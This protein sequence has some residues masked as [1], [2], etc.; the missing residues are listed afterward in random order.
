[1]NNKFLSK[2][3]S[4]FGIGLLVTFLVAYIVSTSISALSFIFS[5][6]TYLIIVLLE[7][8]V[9]IWLSARIHKM[10][11]GLAKGLY[12]AY[13]ALTGLTF[14]SLFVVYELTS[15]IWIFLAS[16]LVFGVF[17]LLGKSGRFDLSRYGIYLLVGL[18]GSVILEVINIF[19]MN[20]T[21]DMII[22]VAVLAIFVTYV[23]YDVRKI[24][25][26]YDS[27]NEAMAVYGAF[28]LYLDFINIFLRLIQLFG[29][30]RN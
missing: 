28:D 21:L 9:A 30:E 4:W 25:T 26:R 14:S 13:S 5:G 7:F 20:H 12:L 19:L 2:V 6:S 29:K 15:I 8:G 11:S 10:S 27:S 16:A 1:M 3:F 23:A 24:I 17:A 22:C 18:L